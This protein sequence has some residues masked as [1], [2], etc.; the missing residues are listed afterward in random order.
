MTTSTTITLSTNANY[1]NATITGITVKLTLDHQRDG[2]LFIELIAPNGT[3]S[4]LYENPGDNGQNFI[5][6]T[7]SDSGLQSIFA[8]TT[9]YSN[10][11]YQPFNPLANLNGSRVNGTYTL[12]IDDFQSN[13]NTAVRW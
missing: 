4:I 6:T 8:G 5:N 9:P 13:Y 2:D 10:G 12:L 3:A 1:A 11:P 7:F